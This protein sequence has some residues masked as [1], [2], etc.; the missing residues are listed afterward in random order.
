MLKRLII[1]LV[2]S[3]II[4]FL[5]FI[6]QILN[7]EPIS[8]SVYPSI[9]GFIFLSTIMVVISIIIMYLRLWISFSGFIFGY[10]IIK[11]VII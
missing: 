11:M 8:Q 3:F 7:I 6:V 4:G 10:R 1:N 5:F 9:L 2:V